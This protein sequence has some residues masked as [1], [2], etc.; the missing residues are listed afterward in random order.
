MADP[1]MIAFTV[2][3]LHAFGER[4]YV[5]GISRMATD[6]PEQARDLR[7]AARLIWVLAIEAARTIRIDGT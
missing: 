7:I 3:E 6:S 2:P 1:T 5:R 4:L